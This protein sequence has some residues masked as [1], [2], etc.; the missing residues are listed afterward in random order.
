MYILKDYINQ[1][2][3]VLVQGWKSRPLIIGNY[4]HFCANVLM[5]V[6]KCVNMCPALK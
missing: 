4:K 3:V 1:D 6:F 5:N 2:S